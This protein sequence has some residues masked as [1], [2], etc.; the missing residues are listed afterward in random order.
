MLMLAPAHAQRVAVDQQTAASAQAAVQKLGVEMMKGNFKYGQDRMYPRWKRRLA[1]RVGGMD[2]LEAQLVAAQ[3]RKAKMGLRVTAFQAKWPASFFKVWPVKKIN[4]ATGKPVMVKAPKV[5]PITGDPVL[6]ENGQ[7]IMVDSFALEYHWLAI[8]PTVTR[9]QIP[10]AK[11]PGKLYELEESSYTV[12]VSKVGKNDWHFLTGLKPT[13]QDLR[14][15]F[16]LLL[17]DD[18]E[19]ALPKPSAREIK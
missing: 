17:K 12:T 11:L 2:K 14:S 7:E 18:L 1:K 19:K 3:Q 13:V 4:Q 16:P 6:D 15:L 8:V 5:D 10:D 9:V